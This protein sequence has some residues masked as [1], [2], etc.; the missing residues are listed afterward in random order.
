ML[1]LPWGYM[2]SSVD[3]L[4]AYT[5]DHYAPVLLESRGDSPHIQNRYSSTE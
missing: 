5:E 4:Y 3:T 1:L 2:E